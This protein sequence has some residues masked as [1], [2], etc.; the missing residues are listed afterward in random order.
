LSDF[1]LL[2]FFLDSDFFLASD[3][4]DLRLLS[5]FFLAPDLSDYSGPRIS[6]QWL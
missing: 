3:L 2:F 1:L 5:D 6:D 4:T